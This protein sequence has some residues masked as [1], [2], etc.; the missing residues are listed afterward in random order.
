M[1]A[2]VHD[3]SASSSIARFG[4]DLNA[5]TYRLFEMDEAT[6]QQLL[7]DDGSLTIKGGRDDDAVLCT[8]DKTYTLRLAESSNSFLLAP[9][10][11]KKRPREEGADNAA[12]NAEPPPPDVLEIQA[13][14]SAHLELIRSAPRTG[15]L[16]ALLSAWPH[17]GAA[18]DE[19][20]PVDDDEA[21]LWPEERAAPPRKRLS[22]AELEA[23]VQ[24]SRAELFVALQHSRAIEVDGGW[25]VLDPQLE[26]DIVECILSLCVEKEWPLNAV[27]TT[28]CVQLAL[29]QF[30]GFDE[31]SVRH[32]LR[33]H[34]MLAA[35]TTTCGWEEWLAA[36]HNETI[37]LNPAAVSRF[38]A[39]ALLAECDSWPKDKFLEAWAEALPSGREVDMTQLDGLAVTLPP[40][41]KVQV[42]KK[43]KDDDEPEEQP[44]LQG[45]PLSSLSLVPKERFAALFLLKKKWGLDELLPYVNDL[46]EPGAAPTKIILKHARSVVANDGSVT[47]NARW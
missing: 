38:R 33:T 24:S 39:R 40:T 5:Q 2:V 30:P 7:K 17:N 35:A 27:P 34:S 3:V 13:S 37:E 12:D 18:E 15:G 23:T 41:P 22:L 28:E 11:E 14:A 25:C 46:V 6:L 43:Q 36:L 16:L 31:L 44:R 45:L 29:A 8:A 26:M 21:N 4:A 10:R 20:P 42:G 19:P 9:E 47:Y 32:C 1:A